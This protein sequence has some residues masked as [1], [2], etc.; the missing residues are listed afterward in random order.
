MSISSRG[1]V[2]IGAMSYRFS[3]GGI[4]ILANIAMFGIVMPAAFISTAHI[5]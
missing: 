2:G 4:R 3:S 5:V 1:F